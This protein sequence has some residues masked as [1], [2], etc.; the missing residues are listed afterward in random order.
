MGMSNVMK[1][2]KSIVLKSFSRNKE[3]GAS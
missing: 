1:T 2:G 3:F